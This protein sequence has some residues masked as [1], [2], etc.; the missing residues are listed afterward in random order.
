[1][2]KDGGRKNVRETARDRERLSEMG[3]GGVRGG[4]V[5]GGLENEKGGKAYKN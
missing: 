4:T 5:V 1:M 2:R 3:E